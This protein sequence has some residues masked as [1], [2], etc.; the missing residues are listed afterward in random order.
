MKY[1]QGI[2]DRVRILEHKNAIFYA[3]TDGK[4]YKALKWLYI[5]AFAYGG[6]NVLAFVLGV[7]IKYGGH[8]SDFTIELLTPGISLIL[9]LAGFV[10]LL[11]KVHIVATALNSIP[12]CVMIFFFRNRLIDEFSADNSVFPQYYWRHLV[13]LLLIILLSMWMCGIALRAEYKTKTLYIK[14]TENLYNLYKVNV[15]SGEELTEE[16]WD[17]FLKKYDPLNYK[18]QFVNLD[19]ITKDE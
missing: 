1:Y 2:L 7:M 5:L 8:L 13:P 19:E 12:S 18:P 6:F 10:L 3:K 11:K 14:V 9:M 17:T 16:E 15:E 4:L